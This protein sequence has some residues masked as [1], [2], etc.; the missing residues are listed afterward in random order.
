MDN[1]AT[2]RVRRKVEVEDAIAANL[3]QNVKD[4]VSVAVMVISRKL[5]EVRIR[6]TIETGRDGGGAVI[7]G[8]S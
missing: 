1:L 7:D 5:T 6:R 8:H 3:P 4:R 2:Y